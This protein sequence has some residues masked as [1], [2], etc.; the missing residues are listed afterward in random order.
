MITG[1]STGFLVV[2]VTT[3]T[4]MSLLN[5]YDH[6]GVIFLMI[7]LPIDYQNSVFSI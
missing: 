7:L 6:V 2:Q 4:N 3:T 1:K 5:S